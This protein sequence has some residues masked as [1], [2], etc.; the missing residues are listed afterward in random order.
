ML[1]LCDNAGDPFSREHYVPGHFTASAF[2][3][4]PT[5]DMLL[6]VFHGKLHRWLQPGGHIEPMDEDVLAA[7]RREVSEEV[8][9]DALSGG[10]LLDVDVHDIPSLR[11]APSHE[12]FDVRFLFH[13][14]SMRHAAGSDAQDSRWFPLDEIDAI[15]SDASVLRAVSKISA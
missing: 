10:T 7:A 5:R 9:I 14:M 6:L 11:G 13:A 2:V 15:A 3:L 12:H 8:G 4:S 1:A